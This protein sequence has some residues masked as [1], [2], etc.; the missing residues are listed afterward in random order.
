MTFMYV[1]DLE[2]RY[3]D[4]SIGAKR[5]EGLTMDAAKKQAEDKLDEVIETSRLVKEMDGDTTF[6]V[7][8]HKIKTFKEEYA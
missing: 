2:V 4:G 7:V 5:F 6:V 8:G 1:S 3:A